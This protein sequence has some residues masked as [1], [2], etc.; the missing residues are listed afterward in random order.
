[1]SREFVQIVNFIN[2]TTVNQVSHV[3]YSVCCIQ[4]ILYVLYT[5]FLISSYGIQLAQRAS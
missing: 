2:L 4:N 3:E 1:M 5:E